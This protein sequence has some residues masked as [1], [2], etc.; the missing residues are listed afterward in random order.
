MVHTIHVLEER[1]RTCSL[2]QPRTEG[3][4]IH[5]IMTPAMD[6]LRI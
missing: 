4:Q 5:L 2:I 1:V 6:V 3:D